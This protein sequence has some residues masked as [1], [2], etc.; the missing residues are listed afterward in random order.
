MYSELIGNYEKYRIKSLYGNK[1]TINSLSNSIRQFKNN[2][3]EAGQILGQLFVPIMS[4]LMPIVNGVTIAIK[5]LMVSIAGIMG[6]KLDLSEF[7][8]GTSNITDDM[9]GLGDS[10]DGVAESAEN[11]KKGVR[12]FDELEVTSSGSDSKSGSSGG[13]STIDLT[14]EILKA[15]EG[16]ENAWNAA[17][18][19]MEN[20]AIGFADKIEKALEPVKKIFRDF[21]IGDFFQ[22]G[23][24]VSNLVIGINNFFAR[25]ID[26]VDWFGIGKK[27][28][29]FFAGINWI[30]VFSSAVRVIAQA[31]K[32]LFEMYLG[33]LLSAPLETTLI[34]LVAIPKLLKA[35]VATKFVTGVKK[36]WKNFGIWGEKAQ[37]VTGVLGGNEAAASGL[38]MFYPKL[39]AK[40]DALKGSFFGFFRD[41]STNGFW[42]TINTKLTNFGS[43][44]SILQSSAITAVAG[45]AEFKVV[46]NVFENLKLGSENLIASIAK[47][48]GVVGVAAA[49]MYT[50]LGPAGLAIAAITGIVAAIKGISD[51]FKEIALDEEV[52]RYG[53][54][55]DNI[56][57]NISER[58]SAIKESAAETQNYVDTAGAAEIS[59]A[60]DLTD[61]YY[62]LAKKENLTNEEKEQMKIWVTQLCDIFPDLNDYVDKETGL[63]TNQKGTIQALID[64]QQEYYKLQAA[65]DKIIDA[66]GKQ[67]EAEEALKEVTENLNKA[68]S[69]LSKAQDEYNKISEENLKNG[70]L[71]AIS[72]MDAADKV[73]NLEK[74]V[75]RFAEEL[76]NAQSAVD[77]T[78][79][80][81]DYLNDIIFE[82]SMAIDSVNYA[83]LIIN[84]ANTIDELHGIWG[85]DG[86]QILGQDA[87]NIQNEIEEGLTPDEDGWYKLANGGMVRYGEGLEDG[88]TDIQST[89]SEEDVLGLQKALGNTYKVAYEGGK[90]V[91][92][93]LQDGIDS[94][95]PAKINVTTTDPTSIFNTLQKGLAGKT[96]SL[97][98]SITGTSILLNT[99]KIVASARA[100]GGIFA[101]GKWQPITGYASGGNPISGQI[102]FARENGPELVGTIGSHTAVM[103]ND[104]IVASVSDGVARAVASV[105]TQGNLQTNGLLNELIHAVREGKVIEMNGREVGRQIQKADSAYINRTGRSMFA[106]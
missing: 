24:D 48:A 19:K 9:D 3:S 5:R 84:A 102:F 68:Q 32:A 60:K 62:E 55:V 43:S 20:T 61:K 36:L 51:A 81:I 2:I 100:D 18:A 70:G 54:T 66:Y 104:Q 7:G 15:T 63:L 64:K 99:N 23:Q 78:T 75:A 65:K 95:A 103:N 83:N 6:V 101:G 96:L 79:R 27:I 8:Q 56:V 77:D 57:N 92:S 33:S 89:L 31:F 13:G 17:F 30:K 39:S 90:L 74:D 38:Y 34:S 91:V 25:A 82:S 41:I 44:M 52:E 50:A 11:A 28:G 94:T 21:V 58:V 14:E 71:F 59:Y 72:T 67:I 10:L 106:Y 98:A 40:I 42:N 73:R 29:K 86:K 47:I 53:D 88:L 49:A 26:N 80:N 105:L 45:F 87:I 35:I 22:A 16:Y 37:L 4:K 46:S 76:E 69:E 93:K 97:K 12:G 85:E 1:L